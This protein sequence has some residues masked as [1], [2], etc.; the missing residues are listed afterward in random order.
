MVFYKRKFCITAL[1]LLLEN[2]TSSLQNDLLDSISFLLLW[3]KLRFITLFFF[4][5]GKNILKT[6]GWY[7]QTLAK[8]NIWPQFALT[9]EAGW[10]NGWCSSRLSRAV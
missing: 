8:A 10:G 6:E 3:V 2:V 4:F 5:K 9:R 1:S 7:F